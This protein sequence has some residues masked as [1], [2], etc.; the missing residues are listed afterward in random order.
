MCPE[1][2]SITC[3]VRSTILPYKGSIMWPASWVRATFEISNYFY[4]LFI[5]VAQSQSESAQSIQRQATGWM[6]WL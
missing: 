3:G 4:C 2:R 1:K 6:A 5:K